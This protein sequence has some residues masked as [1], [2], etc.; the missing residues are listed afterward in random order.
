MAYARRRPPQCL[1]FAEDVS[2]GGSRSCNTSGISHA[3]GGSSD[4]ARR[5]FA[6]D[7]AAFAADQIQVTSPVGQPLLPVMSAELTARG[8]QG[9]HDDVDSPQRSPCRGSRDGRG[10]FILATSTLAPS[11]HS[12]GIAGRRLSE[13]RVLRT[14]PPAGWALGGSCLRK[15]IGTSGSL[16]DMSTK[17]PSHRSP[18]ITTRDGSVA[19]GLSHGQPGSSSACSLLPDFA[20]LECSRQTSQDGLAHARGGGDFEAFRSAP[21]TAGIPPVFSAIF[22]HAS[23]ASSPAASLPALSPRG[24]EF[25]EDRQSCSPHRSPLRA[26]VARDDAASSRGG[27]AAPQEALTIL[28]QRLTQS[29]A[30]AGVNLRR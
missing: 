14:C 2:T 8:E 15:K 29:L 7:A 22:D 16:S 25:T 30:V 23:S 24:S 18:S 10:A 3:S 26:R 4:Q 13:E 21:E 19:G 20:T 28:G 6:E 11:R 1:S 9:R 5:I 17:S 12:A 27:A